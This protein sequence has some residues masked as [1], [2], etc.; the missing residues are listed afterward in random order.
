[1]LMSREP[2]E[3]NSRSCRIFFTEYW[4]FLKGLYVRIRNVLLI[5]TPV[6]VKS[7]K[8]SVLLLA[9]L[10]ALHR[11]ERASIKQWGDTRQLKPQYHSI[12]HLLGSNVSWPDEG[13]SMNQCWYC[14]FLL[15]PPDRG[16]KERGGGGGRGETPEFWSETITLLSPELR[17]L[18]KTR[19]T[20]VG[21]EE[22]QH[23]FLHKLPLH[24]H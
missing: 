15:Q 7:T 2:T 10:L 9:L 13:L 14:V 8:V 5:A 1:M 4:I 17:L 3:C 21:L 22:L 20:S 12:F 18:H 6:A 11:H 19:E 24:I 16:Q 23:L